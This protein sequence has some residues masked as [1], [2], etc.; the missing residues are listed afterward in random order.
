MTRQRYT[1]A[2]I[3]MAITAL[4]PA[5]GTVNTTSTRATP[6]ADEVPD[7]RLQI[8]DL[9]TEVFLHCRGVRLYTSEPSGLLEAQIVVANDGF[10]SRTFGWNFRWLNEAGNLINSKTD[11]WRATS[12]PAG[13]TVTLTD[14]APNASA[15]DFTFE[16]RRSDNR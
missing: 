13:G 5:C 14:L 15:T 1:G 9:L 10:S 8:N 11:V 3:A 6:S 4:L 12:V 7:T 16:L 2:I